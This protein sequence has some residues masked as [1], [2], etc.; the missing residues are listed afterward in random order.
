MSWIHNPTTTPTIH[1]QE[2]PMQML[3]AFWKAVYLLRFAVYM[4]NFTLYQVHKK[5]DM[6]DWGLTLNQPIKITPISLSRATT[7]VNLIPDLQCSDLMRCTL[8]PKKENTKQVLHTELQCVNSS[9]RLQMYMLW[10]SVGTCSGGEVPNMYAPLLTLC[11]QQNTAARQPNS[12][13]LF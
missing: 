12:F 3:A 6:L 4:T 1:C 13:L 2:M 5:K 11:T 10:D 9:E 8:N 7:V